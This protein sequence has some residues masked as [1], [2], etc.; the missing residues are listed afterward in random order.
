MYAAAS[1]NILKAAHHGS[2][3]STSQEFLSAVR[4]DVILLS[5]RND[6]RTED[7]VSRT[8][9]IPVWSTSDCGAVTIR[10]EEGGYILTPYLSPTVSGG[11]EHGS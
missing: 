8:G 7:F 6:T 4:P 11:F 3:S 1:A 5:C 2:R 10:F 9:S